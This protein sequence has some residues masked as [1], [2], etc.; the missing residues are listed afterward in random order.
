MD[1]LSHNLATIFCSNLADAK[2]I[3][4]TADAETCRQAL[5]CLERFPSV[6]RRKLIERRIRQLKKEGR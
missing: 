4:R 1:P 2:D 3:L 6:T 5:D